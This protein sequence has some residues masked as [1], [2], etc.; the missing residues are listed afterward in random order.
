MAIVQIARIFSN[1]LNYSLEQ[2]ICVFHRL[3]PT[4]TTRRCNKQRD[5]AC[6]GETTAKLIGSSRIMLPTN[7]FFF[8]FIPRCHRTTSDG[9]IIIHLHTRIGQSQSE[10]ENFHFPF[11]KKLN[12]VSFS[13]VSQERQTKQQNM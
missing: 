6:S 1:Q 4:A 11:K 8:Y 5:W 12:V 7:V 2:N 3:R 10:N 13:L 9:N